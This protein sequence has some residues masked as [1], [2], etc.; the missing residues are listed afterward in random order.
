MQITK[1][2]KTQFHHQFTDIHTAI[3][4]WEKQVWWWQRSKI[5]I[6]QIKKIKPNFEDPNTRISQELMNTEIE[7]VEMELRNACIEANILNG[8]A[9]DGTHVYVAFRNQ[10]DATA[11]VLKHGD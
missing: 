10:T 4:F 7:R 1:Y 5:V 3:T 9:S 11:F 2:I 6:L 8:V